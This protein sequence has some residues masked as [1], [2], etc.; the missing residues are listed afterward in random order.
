MERPKLRPVEVVLAKV[1]ERPVYLLRDASRLTEGAVTVSE[2]ILYVLRFFDG[3]HSPLDIRSEYMR[4]F[5]G[6]LFEEQLDEILQKLESSMLLEGETFDKH[7]ES[8]KNEFARSETRACSH[9]GTAYPSDPDELTAM[10]DEFFTHSEGPGAP[11]S[12][13]G[14]AGAPRGLVLPHI[15]IRAGGPCTAWGY[16]ELAKG[17][18]PD[19]LVVLG[20]GH[21]GPE[22][23]F[24][25]T[26]KDFL[27][28]LGRATTDG[29]FV[30]SV[31]GSCGTDFTAGELAHKAEHSVEF[32]VVFLQYLYKKLGADGAGPRIVPVLCSFGFGDVAPDAPN[33]TSSRISEFVAALRKASETCG[34]RVCFLASADLAHL[35]PRYGD[36]RGIEGAEISVVKSRDLEMLGAVERGSAEEFAAIIAEERDG[37]HVCGFSPIYTML[38][39]MEPTSGRL[40]K[41][42]YTPVDNAGS[43]VSFAGMA[44]E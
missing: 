43:I 26:K 35:G 32:Q 31:L 33:D 18:L 10:L 24:A 9:A 11:L 13:P 14:D 27:T 34:A 40:L 22:N 2:D 12:G 15:D 25:V 5:G 7:M 29:S 38:K 20:T 21:S 16:A 23:N 30:D 4:K 36:P 37:R 41:Y 3:R 28:P 8:L 6:F 44:L 42:G 1:S 19:V 39:A 17:K